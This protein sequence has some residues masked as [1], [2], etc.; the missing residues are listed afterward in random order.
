MLRVVDATLRIFVPGD[1]DASQ[2]W[3]WQQDYQRVAIVP[4]LPLAAFSAGHCKE[5]FMTFDLLAAIVCAPEKHG[6]RTWQADSG[7]W[8]WEYAEWYG[9]ATTSRQT[10]LEAAFCRLS[11]EAQR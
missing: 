2:A 6:L 11:A 7:L 10:A 1:V 8:F 5:T 4:Q 9:Q 3:L